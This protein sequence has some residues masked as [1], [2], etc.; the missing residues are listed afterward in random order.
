MDGIK[1]LLI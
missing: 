1:E